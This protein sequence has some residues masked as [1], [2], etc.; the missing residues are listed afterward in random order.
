MISKFSGRYL[1]LD[2]G[3]VETKIMDASISG[4]TITVHNTVDMRDMS[5]F[6]SI[7]SHTL[8]NIKGFVASFKET[9]D[10][11]KIRTKKVLVCS[12]IL[13]IRMNTTQQSSKTYKDTKELDKFYQ[14][15]LG[16]ASSNLTI[17]DYKLYGH[18]PD[19]TELRYQ[20][21]TQK[22]GLMLITDFV[23]SMH[24]AGYSVVHIEGSI[25][26]MANISQLFEHS[27]DLPTLF[28]VDMG[29]SITICAFKNGVFHTS[30]S[31]HFS[32]TNLVKDL[33]VELGQPPIKIKKYL[34][35]IGA[36]RTTATENELY[37]D[38]IDA[39]VYFKI[40]NQSALTSLDMIKKAIEERVLNKQL[41]HYQVQFM[42]GL[43]DIPGMF[44]LFETS[45]TDVPI[46]QMKIES[47][48]STKTLAV[49]NKMN[50]YID[51]KYA[52]CIGVLLGNQFS[53]NINLVPTEA[54]T[55]DSNAAVV[56]FSQVVA[57]MCALA[58]AASVIFTGYYGVQK[59]YY[60][61]VEDYLATT[62]SQIATLKRTDQRYKDYLEA[63]KDVDNVAQPLIDF[64]TRYEDTN[65]CI[66]SVDTPLMLVQNAV[67]EVPAENEVESTESAESTTTEGTTSTDT[68]TDTT[69][70][71][72]ENK[73]KQDLIIRGYATDSSSVTE[74]FNKLQAQEWVPDLAMNGVRQIQLNP[75]EV[76]Y[77]FE[78][79]IRRFAA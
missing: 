36:V 37:A 48:F 54:I 39:D 11:Y 57:G 21:M 69:E 29:S 75:N 19:E 46:G 58:I 26:A 9:M 55:I 45:W 78:I 7:E 31:V 63:I 1:I 38:D 30:R 66:A 74:F 12:T 18:E 25:S 28:M 42:G 20:I 34:Y 4:S 6:V 49:V 8:G 17:S 61:N 27:Y 64:I 40:I 23:S 65:L 44:E 71:T 77:I 33:S 35:K 3:Q 53:R 41:G 60:R 13:G 16:R 51:N 32:I 67:E 14:E 62:N 43:M 68:S 22:A 70:D 73:T 15:Q 50:S 5:P 24:D 2:I 56:M 79:T 10:S 52:T 47:R 76:L 59:Y 72:S